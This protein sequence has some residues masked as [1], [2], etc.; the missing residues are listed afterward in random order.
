MSGCGS[1]NSDYDHGVYNLKNFHQADK[2]VETS[3]R[4]IE[5]R[6]P[7]GAFSSLLPI[8]ALVKGH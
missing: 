1:N 7:E 2:T 5:A 6:R 8:E 3:S 4:F